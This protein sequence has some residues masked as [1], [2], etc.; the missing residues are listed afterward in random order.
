[1]TIN[2]EN[3]VLI[4]IYLYN[5]RTRTN[6]YNLLHVTLTLSERYSL[7]S[8]SLKIS[9]IFSDNFSFDKRCNELEAWLIKRG[10]SENMIR[11]KVLR[12][13][14]YPWEEL[15]EKEPREQ[16]KLT[17]NITYYLVFQNVKEI[18]KDLHNLLKDTMKAYFC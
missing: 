9:Y 2:I 7:Q 3:G 4:W 1:M 12:A 6:I 8:G 18:L 10:Y 16:T 14:S 5:L 17:Q 13:R 15:L 11:K